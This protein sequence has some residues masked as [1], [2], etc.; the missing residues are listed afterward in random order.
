MARSTKVKR[1]RMLRSDAS[2]QRKQR[3][4]ISKP[5]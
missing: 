2:I 4:H 1:D 3:P 5:A